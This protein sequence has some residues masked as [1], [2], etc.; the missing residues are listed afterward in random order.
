MDCGISETWRPSRPDLT[1]GLE[2]IYRQLPLSLVLEEVTEESLLLGM[3]LTNSFQAPLYPTLHILLVE[4]QTKVEDLRIV[5]V[6][7][8]DSCP[9]GEGLVSSPTG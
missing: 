8:P 2:A 6:I 7:V 3:V 1:V 9:A 5:A 4:C